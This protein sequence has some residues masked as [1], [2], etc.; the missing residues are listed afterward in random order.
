MI[1]SFL[2]KV[3]YYKQELVQGIPMV[4]AVQAIRLH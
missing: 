4:C 1:F 3:F 2:Y